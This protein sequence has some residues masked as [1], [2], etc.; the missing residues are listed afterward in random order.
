MVNAIR[1][2]NYRPPSIKPILLLR[3]LFI[4]R[5][6]CAVRNDVVLAYT[7]GVPSPTAAQQ[8]SRSQFDTFS[9]Q[10]ESVCE[11]GPIVKASD[12]TV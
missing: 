8:L 10:G 3:G 2:R 12:R 5:P 6:E 7:F 1:G 4:W 9:A 11:K